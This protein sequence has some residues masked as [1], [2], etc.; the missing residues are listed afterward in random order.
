MA[1]GMNG[2]FDK[3]VKSETPVKMIWDGGQLLGDS[4]AIPKGAKN[5]ELA[6]LFIA[7]A[8]LP[9]NNWRLSK[10]ITYGPANQKAFHRLPK[11]IL[12]DLPTSYI[13][14]LIHCDMAWWAQNYN[15]TLE[16]WYEWKLGK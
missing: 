3:L 13:N 8:T 14:S 2:R 9:E 12:D 10:Y 1:F 15:W 4:W 5:K 11:D 6:M 16:R 7:W